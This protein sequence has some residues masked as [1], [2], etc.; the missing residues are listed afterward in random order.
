M[1]QICLHMNYPRECHLL[2]VKCILRYIQGTLSYG[3]LV[4][5]SLMDVLVVYCDTY[6]ADYPDTR[7]STSGYCIYLDENLVS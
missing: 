1:Q 3:L 2:L 6:W 5:P 7:H 4:M